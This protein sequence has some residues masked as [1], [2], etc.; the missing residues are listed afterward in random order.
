MREYNLDTQLLFLDYEK[1]FDSAQRQI[2]FNI[3]EVRNIPNKL[4]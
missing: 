1:A 3:M 2:L 4:L